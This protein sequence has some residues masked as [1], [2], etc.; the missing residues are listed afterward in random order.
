ML[1]SYF[2]TITSTEGGKWVFRIDFGI[3]M[4]MILL[5][6]LSVGIMVGFLIL[7]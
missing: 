3:T 7:G 1:H 5:L 6:I 4:V 2:S